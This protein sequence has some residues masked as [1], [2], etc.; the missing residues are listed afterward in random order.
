MLGDISRWARRSYV[1]TKEQGW[2]GA[3]KSAYLLYR[4]AWRIGSNFGVGT[5]VFERNWDV[6][7]ILDGTR[8]DALREVA[9]KR[10]GF[11]QI[12]TIWSV[13]STSGEWIENT[14]VQKHA[15]LLA[16]TG[17]VTANPFSTNL[18]DMPGGAELA[19]I[20]EVWRYGFDTDLGTVPP[21]VVTDRALIINR[22]S[23][24]D[25]LIIHYMQPHQPFIAEDAP[26]QGYSTME[27]V[28]K[29]RSAG[30]EEWVPGTVHENNIWYMLATGDISYEE[31][32]ASYQANLRLA[33][34]EVD[35]LLD[36]LSADCVI[37]TSDHGNAAGEW[38][39]FG[40][41]RGFLHPSVRTVPWIEMSGRGPGEYDPAIHHEDVDRDVADVLEALGYQ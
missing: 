2:E 40:H 15:N 33:L 21:Q 25:R 39:M 20:D 4:G 29:N 41:P 5:N 17:Y 31:L 24:I 18:N 28:V 13:G 37:V 14:F 7:I 35:F 11:M 23:D 12:D 16:R 8:V 32:I 3:Q 30:H 27:G 34:D 9:E 6:L 1:R 26:L 22:K 10:D 38:W 19:H 36:N